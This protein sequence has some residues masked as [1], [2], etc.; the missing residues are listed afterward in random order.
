[1]CCL[2]LSL[3]MH[4]DAAAAPTAAYNMTP[5]SEIHVFVRAAGGG[6]GQ[7]AQNTSA[8]CFGRETQDLKGLRPWHVVF[9][10]YLLC[11]LPH[12]RVL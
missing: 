11:A 6:G 8:F 1:M 12:T 4:C 10:V 3:Q 5:A 9:T 2:D 7:G